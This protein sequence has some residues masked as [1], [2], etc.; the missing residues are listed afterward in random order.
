MIPFFYA[1]RLKTFAYSSLLNEIIE[2]KY[3]LNS[4]HPFIKKEKDL[5]NSFV[6]KLEKNNYKKIYSLF[7]SIF[8]DRARSV[9]LIILFFLILIIFGFKLI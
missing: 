3:Y 1:I 5:E 4:K 2:N 9:D 6:S 8:D 7:N